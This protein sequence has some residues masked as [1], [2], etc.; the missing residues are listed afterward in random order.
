MKISELFDGIKYNGK[1]VD[2]EVS[3]LFCDTRRI[4]KGG[5]FFDIQGE[6]GS[7]FEYLKEDDFQDIVAVVSQRSVDCKNNLVV[8]DVKECAKIVLDRFYR[9]PLKKLKLIGITGTNGKTSTA[10]IA[11]DVLNKSG[12]SSGS[13]GTLGAEWCGKKIRI[14]NTTPGL[15]EFYEILSMMIADGVEC[16]VC[17]VSA[18]ALRQ[19]RLWGVR[20]D[21]GV[22]TNLT[23]D[24]L[25]YFCDM[26]DYASAKKGFFQ[27]DGCKLRVVNVD[28]KVGREIAEF[29]EEKTITYGI[30]NPSDVFGINFVSTNAGQEFVVNAM[31][32]VF[33]VKTNL[34]GE[35][36]RYNILA[37]I[38]IC[39]IV[40]MDVES[41]TKGLE[42]ISRIDGRFNVY[43][44][45]KIAIIDYAHTPDGLEKILKEARRMTKGRVVCVFGCGGDRDRSK[46]PLMGEIAE[47]YS[48]VVILTEDNSRG[49]KT[50][51]IIAE[52]ITGMK[53]KPIILEDRREAIGK[54]INILKSG[55][56]AVIAGKGAEKYIEKCGNIEYFCDEEEVQKV[57]LN[58]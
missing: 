19:D 51:K 47:K 39:L 41:V 40:G 6:S 9:Y 14:K 18:H 32:E 52:I 1:Y 46:R 45:G 44:N 12:K 43:D 8:E 25:D 30:E 55:E 31:D 56:I 48:D 37:V 24:H 23:Q 58:T 50:S 33:F 3:S 53:N 27:K 29:N 38:C 28:D 57:L 11:C 17:E 13:I 5:V 2:L 15:F 7:G 36:N 34:R 22:F 35:F 49:E 54:A 10:K 21:V 20:F 26:G 4:V 42:N 16:V